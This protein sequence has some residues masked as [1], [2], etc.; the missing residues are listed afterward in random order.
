MPRAWLAALVVRFLP[1]EPE[2]LGLLA[3][4]RL[5]LARADTRFT[6]E[7][8]L[9]L[10]PDQDRSLWNQPMIADAT[11]LIEQAA[12]LRRPGP[13]QI[14]AAIVA[15][16]AEAPSWAATDWQQILILYDLL[17]QMTPS[18]V[19]KLNRAI[20]LRHAVGLE[21]ALAEVNELASQLDNYHLFHATRAEFLLEL[22]KREQARASALRALGL[23]QNRAEQSLLTRRLLEW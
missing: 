10:L 20:A 2:S 8:E 23:T 13:Y 18:P 5:H 15:C 22:G 7:G 4:M 17:L 11:A 21:A 3:L 1:G 19:V 9:V 6:G 16:H 14:E 12:A